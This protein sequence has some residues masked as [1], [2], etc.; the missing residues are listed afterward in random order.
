MYH[1]TKSKN[2]ENIWKNG[3]KYN[4]PDAVW[5][6]K[7]S[8]MRELIDKVGNNIHENWVN[9]KNSIFFWTTYNKSMRY[10]RERVYNSAVVELRSN[11]DSMW[12]VSNSKVEKFYDN[13]M[14]SSDSVS[15][16]QFEDSA[17]KLV[18]SA[19]KWNGERQEGIEVWTQPPV[20][21]GK[22]HQIYDTSGQVYDIE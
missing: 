21:E 6:K 8:E 15:D 12:C 22:I 2:V 1:V 13:F 3:L 16:S 9:R 10:A 4:P 19:K 14:N 20:S 5:V 11:Q 17:K 18:R 7:R